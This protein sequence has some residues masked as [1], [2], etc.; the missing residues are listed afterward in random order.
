MAHRTEQE[1]F[2][3]GSF[4]GEYANRNRGDGWVAANLSFFAKVLERTSGVTKV[5]ELG[6]N[7][8]LNLRALQYLLPESSLAAMEVEYRGQ[9]GKLFKRDFAGE[10]LDRFGDLSL[11]DYGFVY[12]RDPN[13]SQDDMTWFL[14]EKTQ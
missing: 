3:A 1:R 8:G 9:S 6:A 4:G 14:M 5:L 10:M 13:F 2:W 12:H 11:L 7:I